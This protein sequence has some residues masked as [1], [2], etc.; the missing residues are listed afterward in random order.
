MRALVEGHGRNADLAERMVRQATN[1][2][3]STARRERL[4][5]LVAESEAALLKRLDGFRVKG[6]KAQVLRTAGFRVVR[7]GVPAPDETADSPGDGSVVLGLGLPGLI[8]IG[9]VATT[10]AVLIRQLRR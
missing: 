8:A 9:M 4:V 2:T 3:A 5:D 10:I 6:P 7:S 1:V